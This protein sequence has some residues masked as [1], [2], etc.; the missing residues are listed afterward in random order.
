MDITVI[1]TG[2][3]ARGI[4][5]RLLTA[6][7]CSARRRRRP[8]RSPANCQA[9]RGRAPS[10]IRSPAT[11]S[12][13]LSWYPVVADVLGRYG[14][15]LDGKIVVDIT[16]PLDVDAFEPINIE[17]GSGAQETAAAA[18]APAS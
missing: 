12:C 8:R 5:T 10:A 11:S 7:R 16:N 13:L 9:R 2:N 17:A 18:P 1:G 4:A 6:S 15:Q 3:M 14:S